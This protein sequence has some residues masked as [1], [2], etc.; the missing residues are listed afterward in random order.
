MK[1]S[2]SPCTWRHYA[3]D[4]ILLCVRW[5]CRYSLSYRDPEEMMRERGRTVNHITIFRRVY[6][7]APEINKRIRP[8]L[9]MSSTSTEP[10]TQQGTEAYNSYRKAATSFTSST[11]SPNALMTT[12]S[13]VKR[14]PRPA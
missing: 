1:R 6:K 3:P 7:Y 9:E 2:T 5:Y 8:H 4:I 12:A 10:P 13:P 11:R 14:V